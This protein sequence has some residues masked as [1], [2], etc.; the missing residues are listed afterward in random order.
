M[1]HFTAKLGLLDSF[2]G[3]WRFQHAA[4][5]SS[6]TVEGGGWWGNRIRPKHSHFLTKAVLVASYPPPGGHRPPSALGKVAHVCW[7]SA[8]GGAAACRGETSRIVPWI[9]HHGS[10]SLAGSP[11]L[12]SGAGLLLQLTQILDVYLGIRS[13]SRG[14]GNHY[15]PRDS[16]AEVC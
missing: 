7:Q 5:R 6:R 4:T 8:P 9:S 13:S 3:I 2:R 10:A 15:S 16:G 11:R 12:R 1:A 14:G